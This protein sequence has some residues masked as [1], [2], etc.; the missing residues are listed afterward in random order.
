[1]YR[2]YDRSTFVDID[3]KITERAV[4]GRMSVPHNPE[5]KSVL[6][7]RGML[8]YQEDVGNL[9]KNLKIWVLKVQKCVYI[10][11]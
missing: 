6:L 3:S 10:P 11:I 4:F 9:N 7:V 2:N 5:A 1:V 8:Q